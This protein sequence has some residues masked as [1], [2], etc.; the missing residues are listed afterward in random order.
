[1]YLKIQASSGILE[2]KISKDLFDYMQYW[3]DNLAYIAQKWTDV[4]SGGHDTNDA[5]KSAGNEHDNFRL[6]IQ[7]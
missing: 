7:L 3:N 1:M 5:R 6:S 4:C 2:T